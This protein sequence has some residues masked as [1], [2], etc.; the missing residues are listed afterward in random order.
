MKR[1]LLFIL[2]IVAM[3]ALLVAD[4]FVGST[5]L[6]L[7]QIIS[8]FSA[9]ADSAIRT[10]VIDI[11]LLK[12]L[13]ALIAGIALS[14]SGLQMQTLFRN[15]LAGPYVLGL[16]SGASLGVALLLLSGVGSALGIAGSAMLGAAAV[17]G[18]LL[19]MNE[20][21]RDIMTLLIL[22]I[23]FSSA[24]GAIVQ[25]LQY[26][27]D[28]QALKSYVVWTMGSLS[29]VTAEQL[30]IL[31]VV[32]IAGVVLTVPT[33]KSLN[34]IELGDSF[35]RN[36]GV[37]LRRSRF[38]I[39]ASTTLLA[40]SVTAFCGPIGFVGLAVPHIARGIFRTAD[41]RILIPASALIGAVLMILCDI[42]SRQFLIPINA[43]TSLA[44]IPVV[45]Y[46]ILRK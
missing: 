45:V 19:L 46:I 26:M 6:T 5:D 4:L 28:E 12:A 30:T 33:L 41:H 9:E 44:G 39:L 3:A 35:A 21:V 42:V 11:R 13:I 31:S 18:L 43:V 17:M 16:S 25:I 34:L 14:I 8:A 20:R 32:V 10:I 29:E 27:S 36:A 38:F 22:G 37:D 1:K 15:P 40:G 24:I 23:L 2:L 7:R